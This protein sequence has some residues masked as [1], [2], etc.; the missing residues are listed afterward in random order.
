[1]IFKTK[2]FYKIVKKNLNVPNVVSLF[3]I[4]LIIPCVK[5]FLDE[6]YVGVAIVLVLSGISDLL[7]GMLARKFSQITDLGRVLDPVADK[8]TLLAAIV[9]IGLKF[10]E[11]FVFVVILLIKDITMIAA[12]IFLIRRNI[13]PLPARWYGKISTIFFYISSIV[14]IIMKAFLGIYSPI[15]PVLLFSITT[16]M[17][18]F[19]LF[20]YF[21][22]FFAMINN[23][24]DEH[25]TGMA[26]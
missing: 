18:I 12:G 7:D 5:F 17:M 19:A 26:S 20:K 2:D 24:N 6:N 21:I 9:C 13:L 15:V 3:R 16:L 22:L 10:N 8:L 4:F 14:I 23:A 11:I 25:N 1:M